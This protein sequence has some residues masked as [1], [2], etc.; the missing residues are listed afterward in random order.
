M[1]IPNGNGQ[2]SWRN[3]LNSTIGIQPLHE[4]HVS[5]RNGVFKLALVRNPI[6]RALSG[7]IYWQKS[8]DSDAD[9]TCLFGHDGGS[10]AC[11]SFKE[12][13]QILPQWLHHPRFKPQVDTCG[14]VSAFDFVGKVEERAKWM[15]A[16]VDFI[17][18]DSLVP[19][20]AHDA[21]AHPLEVI[22]SHIGI[23]E[24][25]ML[26]E[27]Y[28]EDIQS[29]GYESEIQEMLRRTMG[30]NM[31]S[32]NLSSSDA[33]DNRNPYGIFLWAM[34]RS[35]TATFYNTLIATAKV[36]GIRI[37]SCFGR[38]EGFRNL[39]I[40][41]AGMAQCL[42]DARKEG[43]DAWFLHIAPNNRHINSDV[44]VDVIFSWAVQSGV[45]LVVSINR[46]NQLARWISV[47]EH[48]EARGK[49]LSVSNKKHSTA[50]NMSV[51]NDA[52][53]EFSRFPQYLGHYCH[54]LSMS[55]M[56]G[57]ETVEL[58]FADF[59]AAPCNPVKNVLR[60]VFSHIEHSTDT[61]QSQTAAAL[62]S[63]CTEIKKHTGTS[64]RQW[65]LEDRVGTQAMEWWISVLSPTRKRWML[66]LTN[67]SG[68][69]AG[70]RPC[71]SSDAVVTMSVDESHGGGQAPHGF[72]S[73]T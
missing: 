60:R 64:K 62:D 44:S 43:A 56:L 16:F 25:A 52:K 31:E 33:S 54:G 53:D 48:Q 38:K 65:S 26:S 35:A 8:A 67:N 20:S 18:L 27:I 36:A 73:G 1:C 50:W 37:S 69:G 12:F 63:A 70:Y 42:Q 10:T 17:G 2:S 71:L 6:E 59:I 49:G 15:P 13:I 23:D 68:F 41:E 21:H 22:Q 11:M 7:Y 58:D 55:N 5:Q 46:Q 34:G 66:D 24:L 4:P 61:V 14:R 72:T 47:Q 19:F 51:L 45:K 30:I 40:T 32:E 29:F 39:A 28:S 3:T 57:V 9:G